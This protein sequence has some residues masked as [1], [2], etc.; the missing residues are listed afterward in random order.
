METGVDTRS[1]PSNTR[2]RPHTLSTEHVSK[3]TYVSEI[4]PRG[5]CFMKVP[6]NIQPITP[7]HLPHPG[8]CYRL[9]SQK[10]TRRGRGQ[11]MPALAI[12]KREPVE[13]K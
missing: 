11:E 3:N 10:R 13:N 4:D 12:F 7:D 1:S 2:P 9:W 6:V 8:A 5:V